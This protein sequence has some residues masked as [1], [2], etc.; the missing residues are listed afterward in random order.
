M[1]RRII[2]FFLAALLHSLSA[3]ADEPAEVVGTAGVAQLEVVHDFLLF[4]SSTMTPARV[5]QYIKVGTSVHIG[6]LRDGQ[7]AEEDFPAVEIDIRGDLCWIHSKAH[8]RYDLT[9]G[10]TIYVQ[11][12]RKLR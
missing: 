2:C 9:L 6:Y 4:S 5:P 1:I 10:D 11:P 12:C 8:S 3:N 7:V